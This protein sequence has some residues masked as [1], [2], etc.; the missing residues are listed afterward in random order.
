[1]ASHTPASDSAVL[2]DEKPSAPAPAV[3]ASTTERGAY[4]LLKAVYKEKGLSGWY[5]GLTAQILKAA[6]CQGQSST[7]FFIIH[8]NP[9]VASSHADFAGIL[10]VSKDQFE[11]WTRMIILL[12]TKFRSRVHVA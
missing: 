9:I 10:F 8:M 12:L 6:L 1:M 5:Q 7:R 3:N 2:S 4:S 11:V